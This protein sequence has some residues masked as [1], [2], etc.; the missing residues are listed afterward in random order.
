MF[1]NS[2]LC[3]VGTCNID[4]GVM[5][6]KSAWPTCYGTVISVVMV[7]WFCSISETQIDIWT[8]YLQIL[9]WYDTIIHLNIAWPTCHGSLIQAAQCSYFFLF[10]PSFLYIPIFWANLLYFPI[11][12]KNAENQPR[13]SC[14]LGNLQ[15][16]NMSFWGPSGPQTPAGMR[17]LIFVSR[18]SMLLAAPVAEWVRL[19]YFSALNHSIISPLCLV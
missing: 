18:Y 9:K 2:C 13:K 12:L 11:F 8:S 14:F 3:I 10:F 7:Q 1:V 15:H 17:T 16:L 5:D 6:W 4:L 19:L